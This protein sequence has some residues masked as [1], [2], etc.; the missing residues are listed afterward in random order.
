MELG[1]VGKWNIRTDPVPDMHKADSSREYTR[2]H[3]H[4][5]CYSSRGT[6]CS[7]PIHTSPTTD[8]RKTELSLYLWSARSQLLKRAPGGGAVRR[9]PG[10]LIGA[11]S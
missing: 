3:P 11:A 6:Y 9:G 7:G 1:S 5:R 10:A 4:W 8:C 2:R